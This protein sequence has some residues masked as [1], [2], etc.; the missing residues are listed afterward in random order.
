MPSAG[1]PST[2]SSRRSPDGTASIRHWAPA[3]AVSLTTFI[4]VVNAS[5]M[6]VAI[7]TM[8]DEFETTVTVIQ[9]AVTLYSLVIAALI[10]PAG[11]LPSRRSSRRVMAIALVVYAAGTVVAAISWNTTVLYVGWAVI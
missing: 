10:L 1:L 6:N 9:G 11:T 7:P 5:L 2:G 8:V 4:I 3:I